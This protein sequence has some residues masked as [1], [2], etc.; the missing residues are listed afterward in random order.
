[1]F[2]WILAGLFGAIIGFLLVRLQRERERRKEIHPNTTWVIPAIPLDG[3]D[4]VFAP[5]PYGATLETEDFEL[6]MSEEARAAA[7]APKPETPRTNLDLRGDVCQGAGGR[8]Y[9]FILAAHHDY[10]RRIPFQN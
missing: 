5:G 8:P 3:L 7:A 10:H 2:G 9:G 4:P 6:P 1:M